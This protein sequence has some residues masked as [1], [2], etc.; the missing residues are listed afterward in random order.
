MTKLE[1]L[2][3]EKHGQYI[4]EF[5]PASSRHPEITAPMI[6]AMSGQDI[7]GANMGAGFAYL[8]R[9]LLMIDAAHKHNFDQFLFFIG[10]DL[11]DFTEFDAE[12]E[13]TL[14]GKVNLITYA[15]WV[16]IPKGMMHCPLNV[17]RVGKPIIFIDSRLTKEASVR[18]SAQKSRK[19]K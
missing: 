4:S 12:V 7:E 9:P 16:F 14:D 13:L 3:N 8:T 10:G 17:K 6:V 11:N 5:K 15:S 2:K 1:E 18:A 19:S